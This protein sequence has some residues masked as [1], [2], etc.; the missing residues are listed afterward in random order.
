VWRCRP[1]AAGDRE[2]FAR[3]WAWDF[4]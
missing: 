3:G 1:H 2:G 4:L